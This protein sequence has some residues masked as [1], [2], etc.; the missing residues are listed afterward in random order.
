MARNIARLASLLL[1]APALLWSQAE[2]QK[3]DFLVKDDTVYD[4]AG[5]APIWAD[6]GIRGDRIVA[7]GKLE[8][9]QA[10]T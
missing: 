9:E 1:L 10:R 3:F 4:G 5:G 8:R 2:Q 6:V 7:I